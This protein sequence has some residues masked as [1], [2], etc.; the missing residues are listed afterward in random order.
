MSGG[1]GRDS[2]AT[3][4]DGELEAP[5]ARAV[6]V[7]T[8]RPP[9]SAH[10]ATQDDGIHV[11]ATRADPTL[12]ETPSPAL[13]RRKELESAATIAETTVSDPDLGG[14]L[15]LEQLSA[16]PTL[17]GDTDSD[18]T[19]REGSD[20]QAALADKIRAHLDVGEDAPRV[21]EM[22]GQLIGD[23]Y[24]VTERIGAGGMGA[25]YRATQTDLGREVAVKVLLEELNSS[26]TLT[27]RFTVEALA[28]SRLRHP[29]TIQI[30]DFGRTPGGR[31]YIAM[32]LL[33]GDTLHDRLRTAG[34]LPVRMALR[35]LAD[36]AAALAEA[37]AKEIVHRDLKPEN[38]FL[39]RV[40]DNPDFV[41]VLDFGVAKLR[42]GVGDGK[43]TLT[44]AGSIFGT[45]RYMSPEQASARA[46]DARSDLYTVGVILFELLTGRPP[47]ESEA[48]LSL[49]LA[50]VNDAPPA[51]AE[52]APD[53]AIP[54][55]VEALVQRLLAKKPAD[56]PESARALREE[57]LALHDA[58]PHAFDH[59]VDQAEA[60]ALGVITQTA[61]TLQLLAA[62]ETAPPIAASR[63]EAPPD[64]RGLPLPLLG[65]VALTL[66]GLLAGG[67]A[68]RSTPPPP[69][70]Q[71]RPD[72]PTPPP[73]ADATA[74]APADA[75]ATSPPPADAVASPAAAVDAVPTVA[76]DASGGVPSA[77]PMAPDAAAAAE[78]EPTP[79][80]PERRPVRKPRVDKPVR[81]DAP[82]K[83]P[84]SAGKTKPD[85]GLVDDLM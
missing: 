32:E 46:V 62:A 51:M 76:V 20:T 14:A 12:G 41:K 9:G 54:A 10:D 79:A 5:I 63:L 23:R 59:V 45:P 28:V 36:V 85:P 15:D 39:V 44:K 27:R 75:G 34:H 4:G 11:D 64:K 61:P 71:A 26:E 31:L 73:A 6:T 80:P 78:S 58:L 81:A 43:G 47:F 67:L 83:K 68:L 18:A 57:L 25:V 84:P 8:H 16:Q 50:H 60:D 37:H 70:A 74:A 42:D 22:I 66:I 82:A 30:Y 35:I 19:R 7:I 24:R 53:V 40:G 13:A 72:A 48:P 2:D 21:D 77:A 49:L 56:R 17:A 55:D 33:E 3:I 65:G 38:I 52:V 69:P 29:N 1:E